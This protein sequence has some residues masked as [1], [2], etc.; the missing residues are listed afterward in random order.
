MS[1]HDLAADQ[2]R[3]A[4]ADRPSSSAVRRRLPVAVVGDAR[5]EDRN[6]RSPEDLLRVGPEQVL[7]D[8]GSSVRRHHDEIDTGPRGG[9]LDLL[10]YRSKPEQRFDVLDSRVRRDRGCRLEVEPT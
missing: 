5:S 3:G 10:G 2:T 9:G 1:R 8:S 7:A 4:V 6:R